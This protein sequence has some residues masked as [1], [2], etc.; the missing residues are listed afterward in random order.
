MH[1]QLQL[2]FPGETA[3]EHPQPTPAWESLQAEARGKALSRLAQLIARMLM[4][5]ATPERETSDE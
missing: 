2:N 5:A 4:D 1:P 3:D